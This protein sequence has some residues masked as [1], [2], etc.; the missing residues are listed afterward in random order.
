MRINS[1]AMAV[2]YLAVS[3]AFI[4]CFALCY[5]FAARLGCE[6]R[7][8]NL[9]MN[10]SA[11]AIMAAYFASAGCR[12]HATAALL[13]IVAG[14]FTYISTIAFFYH[15]RGARLALSWT[16]IG[17]AVVF[18]VAASIVLWR[19][20]PSLK[21]WLGLCVLAVAFVLLGAGRRAETA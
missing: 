21:Q 15:M 7:A 19:E 3:I 8:V 13:G 2:V 12:Y 11:T 6:L 17:M 5:K 16:V 10:V 4:T 18:P 9:W 14:V 20:N 1:V